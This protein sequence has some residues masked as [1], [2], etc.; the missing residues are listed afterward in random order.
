MNHHLTELTSL[1]YMENSKSIFTH[2]YTNSGHRLKE[3]HLQ[4]ALLIFQYHE[5][6]II[7]NFSDV[8]NTS[9]HK[10]YIKE[11]SIPLC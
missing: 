7:T 5:K 1:T 4:G 3:C 8:S 2:S 10:K 9:F 11:K 6:C